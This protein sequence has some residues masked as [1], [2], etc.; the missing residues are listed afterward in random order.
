MLPISIPILIVMSISAAFGE[1]TVPYNRGVN[2][3]AGISQ[4]TYNRMFAVDRGPS[5]V[6]SCCEVVPACWALLPGIA[7]LSSSLPRP[8]SLV[9]GL[10]RRSRLSLPLVLTSIT[11]IEWG[12]RNTSCLRR[13]CHPKFNGSIARVAKLSASLKLHRDMH[14]NV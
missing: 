7:P 11:T 9:L 2:T 4:V 12:P 10:R 13:I 6:S 14:L 3:E 1:H 5:Q 8:L